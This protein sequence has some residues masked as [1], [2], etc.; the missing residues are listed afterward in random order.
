MLDP[1]DVTACLV[2]RGDVD[3]TPIYESLIFPTVILWDNS[4]RQDWKVAGRYLDHVDET[5]LAVGARAA[6]E[7]AAA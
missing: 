6:R 1:T 7:D 5:V 3:M 4:K 2:T